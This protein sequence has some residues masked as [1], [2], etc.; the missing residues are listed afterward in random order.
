M[1]GK[2]SPEVGTSHAAVACVDLDANVTF[3]DHCI[4]AARLEGDYYERDNE[5]VYAVLRTD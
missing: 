5:R 2:F 4:Q 1:S 3:A